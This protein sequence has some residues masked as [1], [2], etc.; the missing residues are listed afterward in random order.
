MVRARRAIVQIESIA[1][2]GAGVG[3]LP[4]GRA[5]FVQRTAPGDSADIELTADKKRYARGRVLRLLS[6]G[7]ERR[8]APCP[9]YT[10][11]G[12]CTLEHL[13]YA[14][15][16]RA[17][18]RIVSD[19]LQ[20]IG[21]VTFELTDVTASPREFRYRN[22]VSFTLVRTPGGR[23]LAGFHEI[24]RPDRVLDVSASCLLPEDAIAEAW[25]QLRANW[26]ELANLL[27][28]GEELRLTLRAS[29]TG[30]VTLVIDGGYSRGQPDLLLER[31][32][33]IKSVWQRTGAA[34]THV[35]LAGESTIEET[36][37][38]EDVELSGSVF[39]QVNRAAAELLEEHVL[40]RASLLSPQ[41]VVDAYCGIG[42]HARRL[43]RL[44]ARVVGIEMDSNAVEQA[45]RAEL[46]GCE[47]IAGRVE[48]LISDHLPCDLL[49]VNP[50]RAGLAQQI[51]EQLL[52][53]RAQSIIYVS[54][55]P[56]TL[57][58]DLARLAPAYTL[59]GIRCFDLFPQTSHVETVAELACATS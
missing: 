3:R 6:A 5:V 30:A 17:K 26:G 16:L 20:R 43:A 23:V 2:G 32:P 9:H 8:T 1:A 19:A 58:R 46:P 29:S 33:L 27:P 41:T 34:A 48:D 53:K 59:T 35:L 11:C 31:V 10:R 57:A 38:E 52:N 7:P 15:Q 22:R 37:N 24:D 14:A 39:L 13:E 47:F 42:L 49:I 28:S 36:W 54:C 50:P 55:D 45:R 21:G 12:G 18:R 44:G 51:S 56:A 4:D 25:A 40:E